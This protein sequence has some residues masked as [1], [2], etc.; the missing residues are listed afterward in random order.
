MEMK[1]SNNRSRPSGVKSGDE[2]RANMLVIS[3]VMACHEGWDHIPLRKLSRRRKG[4]KRDTV[5]E[6]DIVQSRDTK[7]I[8][9]LR[10]L[11]LSSFI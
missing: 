4:M 9:S 10:S 1:Q 5:G 3:L 11:L 7:R 2:L 8:L 6:K